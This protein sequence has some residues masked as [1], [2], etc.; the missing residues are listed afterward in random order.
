VDGEQW[1]DQRQR[2]SDGAKLGGYGD[3]DRDQQR[4]FQQVR[5]G[6]SDGGDGGDFAD[7]FLCFG[8][9]QSFDGGS[10]C[11]ITMQRNGAGDGKLQ[12]RG[13]VDCERRHD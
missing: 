1:V 12:L 11:D 7:D 9:L 3:G 10:Q 13:E 4:R 6:D 5:N 2:T 8:E